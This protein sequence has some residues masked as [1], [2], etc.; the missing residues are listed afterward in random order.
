[1]SQFPINL[2]DLVPVETNFT[3][4]TLPGQTFTLCRW[5]L[6]VRAWAVAKYTSPGLKLIFE[7]QRIDEIAELTYFML[8]DKAAFGDS[9]DKFLD[10]VVS[11][12]DQ[13]RIIKALLGAVGIGE[14]EIKKITDSIKPEDRVETA[15]DPKPQAK[16]KTGA[17]SSMR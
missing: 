13:V 2:E 8:K 3:L 14:P 6:R 12:G 1:M 15:A 7:Q 9:K 4:D 17:K 5:S 11:I 10:S 16:R